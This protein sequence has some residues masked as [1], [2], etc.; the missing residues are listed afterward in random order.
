MKIRLTRIGRKNRPYYRIVVQEA[1]QKIN[2]AFLE[3]IGV[4]D[5]L[6]EGQGRV[7]SERFRL[8]LARGAKASPAVKSLVRRLA[9][10]K[11]G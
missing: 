8:W 4:Y 7:D 10:P 5:P 9:R 1:R 2:G 3:S 6:K 11:A